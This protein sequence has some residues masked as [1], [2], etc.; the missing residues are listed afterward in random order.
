[1]VWE[2]PAARIALDKFIQQEVLP[3]G[4]YEALP[5]IVEETYIYAGDFSHASSSTGKAVVDA[6]HRFAELLREMDLDGIMRDRLADPPHRSKIIFD[7]CFDACQAHQAAGLND[8]SVG[9]LGLSLSRLVFVRGVISYASGAMLWCIAAEQV[10]DLDLR[11]KLTYAASRF[12]EDA[13]MAFERVAE[14]LGE[15]EAI[16][17]GSAGGDFVSSLVHVALGFWQEK[18]FRSVMSLAAGKSPHQDLAAV[19]HTVETIST[20]RQ[21]A[22][23]FR[24]L[25]EREAREL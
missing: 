20:C 1:M 15:L 14:E 9:K 18:L 19:K 21:K 16:C 11:R 8:E 22:H 5:A 4:L 3:A 23:F 24:D 10:P 25:I 2:T 7:A 6:A 17:R 12:C 13:C